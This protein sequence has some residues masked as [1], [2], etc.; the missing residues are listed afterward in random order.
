VQTSL[1]EAADQVLTRLTGLRWSESTIQHATEGAGRVVQRLPAA[2]VTFGPAKPWDGHKD[3]EGKTVAYVWVDATGVGIEGP[4]GVQA[5]GRRI[6]VGL[7]YNP[8]P[9]DPK[10]WA[11][12]EGPRPSWQAR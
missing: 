4:G 9:E 1:A 10:R 11:K 3:A 12:P 7:I 6:T 5:E 8:V 2:G